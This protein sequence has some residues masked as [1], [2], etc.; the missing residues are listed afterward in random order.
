MDASSGTVLSLNSS[1]AIT[2]NYQGDPRRSL[3]LSTK[4]E[5]ISGI[6]KGDMLRTSNTAVLG[7]F[8]ELKL[9]LIGHYF[10]ALMNSY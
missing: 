3:K 10:A 9:R 1:S 4:V 6:K 5:I 2:L 8:A 7:L